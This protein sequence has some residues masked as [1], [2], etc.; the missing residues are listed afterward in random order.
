M[1]YGREGKRYLR[2]RVVN[3]NQAARYYPWLVIVDLNHE[4]DCAPSLRSAW[5]PTSSPYMRFRVAI[6]AVESW[7]L[8]DTER[9]SAFLRVPINRVPRDVERLGDPKQALLQLASRSSSRAIREDMIPRPGSGRAVGRAYSSRLIEFVIDSRSGW[10]PSTA[11]RSS[12]SLNRCLLSVR[13]L[14]RRYRQ[15]HQQ[16]SGD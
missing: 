11:A 6:R 8:A 5:L 13:D 7:L 16:R 15:S 9:I 10:R 14:V 4:A 12:N 3:Y 1:V 2:A